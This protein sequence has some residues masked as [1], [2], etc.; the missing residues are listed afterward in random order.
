M[1]ISTIKKEVS[2]RKI[3]TR[4]DPYGTYTHRPLLKE[5]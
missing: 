3:R 1:K 5:L 2:R 4:E